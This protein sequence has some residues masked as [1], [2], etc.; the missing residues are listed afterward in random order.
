MN[1]LYKEDAIIEIA[2]LAENIT[3]TII[4]LIFQYTALH[5]CTENQ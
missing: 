5:I 2:I 4:S 3:N 1:R